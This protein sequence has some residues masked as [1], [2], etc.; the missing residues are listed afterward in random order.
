[1]EVTKAKL[2]ATMHIREVIVA[3]DYDPNFEKI[4]QLIKSWL[5]GK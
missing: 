3:D 2:W 5:T 4:I 1:M